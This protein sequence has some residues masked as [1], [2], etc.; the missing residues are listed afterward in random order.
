MRECT[1]VQPGA[2]LDDPGRQRRSAEREGRRRRR[3]QN[4]AVNQV[5]HRVD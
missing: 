3:Q 4:R 2:N 1:P 5:R